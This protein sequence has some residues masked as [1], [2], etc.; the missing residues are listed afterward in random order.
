MIVTEGLAATSNI[1]SRQAFTIKASAKAFKLLSSNL[2]SDKPLAIVREIGCNALDSHFMANKVDVPFKIVLPS[3]MHPYFEVIDYG[4]G[5]NDDQ[6]KNIFTTYFESTKTTS[7]DQIGAMG[8][9][10]KS[11]F[12]YTDAF[13]VFARQDGVQNM[14]TCFLNQSGAPELFLIETQ[15]DDPEKGIKFENGV[16]I[17][18]PV[19]NGDYQLFHN[20]ARKAYKFFPVKPVVG[21][22]VNWSW[23]EV[24]YGFEG[25]NFKT[26]TNEKA[27][28]ALMGPVAYPI[29]LNQLQH[30]KIPADPSDPDSEETILKVDPFIALYMQNAG[31]GFVIQYKIGDLD[32][33]AGREGLSYDKVTIANLIRGMANIRD[34]MA[35]ELQEGLD[36]CANMYEAIKFNHKNDPSN[37]FKLKFNGRFAHG[38]TLDY[39]FLNADG[40]AK[41]AVRKKHYTWAEKLQAVKADQVHVNPNSGHHIVL[42]DDKKLYQKRIRFADKDEKLDSSAFFIHEL[43]IALNSGKDQFD[44]IIKKFDEDGTPWKYLSDVK[45][46]F[47]ERLK[48]EKDPNAAKR[49]KVSYTGFY[50]FVNP[51]HSNIAV[52]DYKNLNDGELEDK[53]CAYIR[54]ST[55]EKRIFINDV[56]FRPDE[57]GSTIWTMIVD[58]AKKANRKIVIVTDKVL[59]KI[60]ADWVDVSKLLRPEIKTT[61]SKK[62]FGEVYGNWVMTGVDMKQPAYDDLMSNKKV[63]PV[64]KQYFDEMRAFKFGAQ[65][66]YT[67]EEFIKRAYALVE[68][69]TAVDGLLKIATAFKTAPIMHLVVSRYWSAWPEKD[70][71]ESVLMFSAMIAHGIIDE[72]QMK[73]FLAAK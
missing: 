24:G 48:A 59:D 7:N 17:K 4:T 8:L 66:D 38:P 55:V 72:N 62:T 29:D 35:K 13:E 26:M 12:S 20:A 28:Y 16:T 54:W 33:N 11:P 68:N 14:Y 57:L 10:S 6:V 41:F 60:P 3:D 2:Y 37:V 65:L 73:E 71:R 52:R 51:F 9:G 25:T 64:V 58:A 47:P 27:I 32:V 22:N 50:H 39:K 45:Y 36:K 49:L 23:S 69:G 1:E 31:R 53:D 61:M 30:L 15:K 67:T 56:R 42:I 5:L 18:V 46:T 70:F 19:K 44:E 63:V 34:E 40:T 21:S 43:D